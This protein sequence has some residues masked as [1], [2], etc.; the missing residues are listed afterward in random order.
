MTADSTHT[1]ADPATAAIGG[2]M[3]EF[4]RTVLT[5]PDG[6][7][8]YLYAR[9]A[10]GVA[11]SAFGVGFAAASLSVANAHISTRRQG[12]SSSR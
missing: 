11:L 10:G 1:R 3:D 2:A 6:G 7:A 4:S 8:G 12:A 9:T 5:S